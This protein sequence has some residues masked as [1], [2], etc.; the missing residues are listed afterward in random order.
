MTSVESRVLNAAA[1]A[2]SLFTE[3]DKHTRDVL[4]RQQA[5]LVRRRG[6]LVRR[7]LVVADVVG[8]A[9]AFLIVQ[10]L[11]DRASAD[12]VRPHLEYLL[13]FLTLPAWIVAAKLYGL[14]DHDEERTDH[15]TV[16]DL[17]GVFHMVTV[18]L[19]LLVILGSA[20]HLI[21]PSVTRLVLFWISALVLV[22]LGRASARWLCRRQLAYLQ[23]TVIVGAGSVGQL[24][25]RKVIQHREYGMNIVGFV[26][27]RPR[28]LSSEL[29]HIAI[30]GS[31]ERLPALVR[32]LWVDRVIIAF[33]KESHEETLALIRSLKDL[34][35][36]IDIVP[37]LFELVS[38]GVS[39]HT[40]EGLPLMGLPPLRLA[41]SSRVLKRS[42]DLALGVP[43]LV[44]LAPLFGYVAL[45][46][47]LESAGPAFFRQV[48]VGVNG[49]PFSIFKFRTMTWDA[50]ERKHEL[51]HLNVHARDGGDPRMFKI[52]RDPRVTPFGAFLRRYSLD[53]L[54]Q[55]I[56]VV[57]GEMSLVG[58]R[59]LVPEEAQHVSDWARKRLAL[60]PGITGLWQVLGRSDIPFEEMT[61]LDY[62][63]VTTWSLWGDLCL[64]FRTMPAIFRAPRCD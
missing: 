35:V 36:Q 62:L 33:S 14:Y 20:T 27:D 63:Y 19:W 11:S 26:D 6:W 8:L 48:R 42:L 37:R 43:A 4:A 2:E 60:K 15:G 18:G 50:D 59:P 3:L 32:A 40:V 56:N 34:E 10:V 38:P 13:F 9:A 25:A 44:L 55:L 61:K 12:H 24:V 22:T 47:R 23:N 58:P 1:Q 16:D 7:A 64:L 45:R 28:K 53:E 31:P 57:R 21:D 29:Q 46:I 54:P 52:P 5:S 49:R 51:A 17:V 39:V 30:L 41:R